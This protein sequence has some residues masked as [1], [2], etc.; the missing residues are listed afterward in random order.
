VVVR[1][2][3]VGERGCC[4]GSFW[5]SSILTTLQAMG[6]DVDK[7]DNLVQLL[8]AKPRSA[9]LVSQSLRLQFM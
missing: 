2:V 6:D 8:M 5:R 7:L 9:N 4:F 1:L 3:A